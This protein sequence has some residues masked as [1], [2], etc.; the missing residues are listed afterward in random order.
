[1]IQIKH[2]DIDRI[3]LDYFNW[4]KISCQAR[5]CFYHKIFEALNT[6]DITELEKDSLNGAT[7][8][9]CADRLLVVKVGTLEHLDRVNNG[10]LQVW[11]LPNLQT[12]LDLFAYLSDEEN[13]KN[14]I[15][16]S[17]ANAGLFDHHQ[18]FLFDHRQPVQT[19]HP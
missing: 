18:P 5:I 17:A 3:A 6:G 16:V 7:R 11:V 8:K 1:M 2:E 14:I 4:I 15:L 12:I 13:L 9:A 19:D 10:N